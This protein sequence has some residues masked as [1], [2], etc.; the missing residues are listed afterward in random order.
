[1][2]LL[3]KFH[4]CLQSLESYADLNSLKLLMYD[5]DHCSKIQS[6]KLCNLSVSIK[7]PLGWVRSSAES[8]NTHNA[9]SPS[10]Y[11]V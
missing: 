2:H 5:L 8:V 1:M 9:S 10:W 4:V 6:H 3:C 11:I 7:L